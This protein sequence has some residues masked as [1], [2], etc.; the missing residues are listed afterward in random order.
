MRVKPLV[1]ND[2]YTGKESYDYWGKVKGSEVLGNPSIV[3]I[4]STI[5]PRTIDASVIE[6]LDKLIT[7]D[8]WDFQKIERA[9]LA[10]EGLFNWLIAIKNYCVVFKACEPYRNR[11]D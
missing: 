1:I 10:S 8:R 6:E 4:L 7:S 9:S 3:R 5:D 11:I 2:P